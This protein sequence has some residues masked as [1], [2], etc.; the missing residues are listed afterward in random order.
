MS[1][2][3]LRVASGRAMMV[4]WLVYEESPDQQMSGS[5]YRVGIIH[6]FLEFPAGHDWKG[7]NKTLL[8]VC[9][10]VISVGVFMNVEKELK[11]TVTV[12][13]SRATAKAIPLQRDLFHRS[14]TVA[15]VK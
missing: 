13:L 6:E 3:C 8:H 5:W 1:G 7:R 4:E 15:A 2:S 14:E 11:G 10:S 9:T 12:Q